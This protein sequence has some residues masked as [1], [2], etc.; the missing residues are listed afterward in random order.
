MFVRDVMEV[1]G[2]DIPDC[3]RLCR[4]K[5]AAPRWYRWIRGERG[6]TAVELKHFE[7]KFGVNTPEK[8]LEP[9]DSLGRPIKDIQL[10][11]SHK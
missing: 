4:E 5:V 1:R 10:H 6:P 11:L 2:L 8:V 9:E 3:Q 7:R